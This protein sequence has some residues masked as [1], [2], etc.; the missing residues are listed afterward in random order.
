MLRLDDKIAIVTGAAQGIGRAIALR[1][2]QSGAHVA[3]ADLNFAG[4]EKVAGEVSV[5]GV[6]DPSPQRR[7]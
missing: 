5:V 3:V 7:L 2:A 4:V 6:A 1:L